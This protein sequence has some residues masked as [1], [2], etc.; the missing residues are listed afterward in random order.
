MEY[1]ELLE[2]LADPALVTD[3]VAFREVSQRHKQL[4]GIVAAIAELRGASE[5]R[6]AAREMLEEADAEEREL[7]RAEVAVADE[8]V[9]A[10][11]A[12]LRDLLLPRDPN[13]GRNVI[14]SIRGAE[15]GE[16]ANLFAKDLYE[17]YQHYADRRGWR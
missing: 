13:D 14:I 17:M 5:D 12:R 8:R 3:R 4:E 9:E 15:G 10:L 11:E 6:D 2:R 16:E 7:A 1:A